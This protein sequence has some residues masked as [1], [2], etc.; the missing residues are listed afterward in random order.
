VKRCEKIWAWT[1]SDIC[2]ELPRLA[3][4]H[5]VPPFRRGIWLEF[6][7]STEDKIMAYSYIGILYLNKK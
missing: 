1:G 2:K 5:K 4:Q 7:M 3:P 6:K